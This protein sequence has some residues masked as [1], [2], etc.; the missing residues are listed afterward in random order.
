LA[1][2]FVQPKNGA[3]TRDQMMDRLVRYRRTLR[4]A[5]LA[6]RD[7]HEIGCVILEQPFFLNESAWIPQPDT[8]AAN[9][10]QGK[11]YDIATPEGSVLLN[12]IQDRLSGEALTLIES[13]RYGA[14]RSIVPRL[15]QG[16]FRAAVTD[17]Y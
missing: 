12:E 4:P 10:V 16:S 5:S 11:S 7:A 6:E 8:W 1:W 14:P 13:A 9:I 3:A 17:A 15:G 2:D